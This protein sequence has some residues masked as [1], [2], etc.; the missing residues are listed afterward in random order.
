MGIREFLEAIWEETLR[1]IAKDMVEHQDLSVP[2]AEVDVALAGVEEGVLS[3][4][5]V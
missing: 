1:E 5:N 2:L 4:A 3:E